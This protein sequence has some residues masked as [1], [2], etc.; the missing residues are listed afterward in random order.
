MSAAAATEEEALAAYALIRAYVARDRYTA[1]RILGRWA[2]GEDG[3]GFAAVVAS[4]A[5]IILTREAAGDRDGALRAAD[6]ALEVSQG[7]AVQAHQARPAQGQVLATSLF[8]DVAAALRKHGSATLNEHCC[9]L[10]ALTAS[11]STVTVTCA[12]ATLRTAR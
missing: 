12:V 8:R 1:A 10:A 11:W 6:A 4:S 5:A 7:L 9:S 2:S 3:M